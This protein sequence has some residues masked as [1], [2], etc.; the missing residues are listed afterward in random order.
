M[1]RKIILLVVLLSTSCYKEEVIFDA[2]PDDQLRT[3]L[4]LRFN[5]KDCLLDF[6]NKSLRYSILNNSITSFQP[7]VQF[8]ENSQVYFNNILLNNNQINHLGQVYTNV[9]YPVKI[10][11]NNETNH[12]TL[13][14]TDLPIIQIITSNTIYDEPKSTARIVVNYPNIS[15]S[16]FSSYIAIEQRG[17]WN[18]L[19]LDKRS[20]GFSFLSS[21]YTDDIVSNSLFE[22][23]NNVDW[24][25]DGMAADEINMKNKLASNIWK[26]IPND[27]DF[28]AEFKYVELF[29]NNEHHGLYCLGETINAE[30]LGLKNNEGL[31]YK[32][33]GWSGPACF[34]T[35]SSEI[36]TINRWDGWEQKFPS[37]NNKIE[38][39]PLARLRHLIVDSN[40]EDFVNLIQ[41]NLKLEN[42]IDYYLFIN[43]ISGIDNMSKNILLARQNQQEPLQII[44][45]DFDDAFSIDDVILDHN[46]LYKRLIEL[47]PDDFKEKL[48]SRWFYLRDNIFTVERFMSLAEENIEELQSS[49]IIYIENN[50]W[51]SS[52]ELSK[53]SENLE[54]WM[55]NRLAIL[56]IYYSEL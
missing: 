41:S 54:R 7:L 27:K 31:I 12:F 29:I 3:A 39:L 28:S 26:I 14:F 53:L 44:P 20:Y 51:N 13:K 40:D 18:N 33:I 34:E 11:T 10:I 24:I 42:F 36:P 38:W 49:D 30:F 2:N 25:L 46:R 52:I 50:K 47:S 56:D 15:Q 21:R 22:F 4:I 55:I 5:H 9:D 35:S 8:Q 48:K 43:F 19:S 37:A 45:F 16:S 17:G 32:A 23:R 1:R 6:D